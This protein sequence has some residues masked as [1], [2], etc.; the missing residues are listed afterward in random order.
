MKSISKIRFQTLLQLAKRNEL[1][2]LRVTEGSDN[3]QTIKI[4]EAAKARYDVWVAVDDALNGSEALLAVYAGS[5]V[6]QE[7]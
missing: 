7:Q 4:H 2:L 6:S 5:T 3:T 1:T